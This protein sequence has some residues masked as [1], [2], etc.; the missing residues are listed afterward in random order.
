MGETPMPPGSTTQMT[1]RVSYRRYRLHQK[2]Q[3]LIEQR[4]VDVDRRSD[5]HNLLGR[6]IHDEPALQRLLGELLRRVFE[7][8]ADE[9]PAAADAGDLLLNRAL[10]PEPGDGV[11]AKCG[12]VL[13]QPFA[14]DHVEHRF[15]R[16][17]A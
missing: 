4:S 16:G 13:D 2:V 17:H 1:A 9:K 7:L 8:D 6:Q 15:G 3:S 5:P 11:L 10:V 14:L 12:C